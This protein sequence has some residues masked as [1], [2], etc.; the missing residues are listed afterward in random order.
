MKILL[1]TTLLASLLSVSCA[2]A[3]SVPADTI[4]LRTREKQAVQIKEVYPNQIRY[5][6]VGGK[7]ATLQTLSLKDVAY[8][9]YT[10]GTKDVFNEFVALKPQIS[11]VT[12][13]EHR[14]DENL[15]L[16]ACVLNK[17]TQ[18]KLELNG[19][20]VTAES[21]GFAPVESFCAGGTSFVQQVRLREGQNQA[22]LIASN[23]AGEIRSAPLSLWYEKG[24]KR[25]ALVI[26]N[27]AYPLGNKLV[28]P[29]NDATDMANSLK[30]LGFDV[31]TF[32]DLNRQG[33][34]NAINEFG[35][36]LQT[37]KYQVGMFYYAGHGV[38]FEGNNYLVPVDAKPGSAGDIDFVCERVDRVLR[39]MDEAQVATNI[40]VLDAC[41]NNPFDRSFSRGGDDKG[42]SN[43]KAPTGTFIAFATAP[44]KTSADGSG[45][46]GIFTESLLRRMIEPNV[47]IE[48]V[49]KRVR[50]DVMTKT[51]S[52]QTPWDQSSLTGEDFFF[53]KK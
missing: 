24:E 1:S 44:G 11:W 8:I 36:K 25:L 37:A 49:F 46:N 27:S 40:V 48:S 15:L 14:N 50:N 5:Q 21:R 28:N 41:R 3:T 12:P 26:G 35:Q 47:T 17:A 19:N 7:A 22:V 20:V 9:V 31:M 29:V 4:Y 51:N 52:Q 2:H 39:K 32:T 23:E 34:V 45:R 16:K 30:K 6:R 42:L 10:N 38:Q 53:L 18:I 33:L 43:M 13:S